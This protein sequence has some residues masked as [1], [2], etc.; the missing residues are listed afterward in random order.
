M[1]SNKT[2]QSNQFETDRSYRFGDYELDA[3]ER[4]LRRDGEIVSL[5]LKPLEVLLVLLERRGRV[6]S[7]EELIERVWP[8]SVVD[9]A[10]LARHV[11]TL[12]RAL[13]ERPKENG[14]EDHFIQTV[15]GRGYRFVASVRELDEK[16]AERVIHE[17]PAAG[18]A[19]PTV[20]SPAKREPLTGVINQRRRRAA[21]ALAALIAVV[22]A[23]I[24]FSK[25]ANGIESILPH[26]ERERLAKR[27]NVDPE[28]HQAYEKG[29]YHWKKRRSA[30]LMKAIEHFNEAIAR[31]PNYAQPY[32]GL[33]DCYVLMEGLTP[34]ILPP[35][36][37]YPKAK[38][39]A[40]KALQIDDQSAEA[41]TSMGRIKM[42]YDWDWMGAEK[43]FKLAIQ[44]DPDYPTAHQWYSVYLSVMGRHAEAIAAAEQAYALDQISPVTSRQLALNYYRARQYDKAIAH[45][46]KMLDLDP[47]AYIRLRDV[48]EHVYEQL[49]WY[50]Q[51]VAERVKVWTVSG[52]A[53]KAAALKAAYDRSGWKGYMQKTSDSIIERAMVGKVGSSTMAKI[54]A[55]LG[56]KDRTLEWLEKAYD[57]RS[58]GIIGIKS[59]PAFDW[60]HADPR[61]QYLLRRIG[62]A[63]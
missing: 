27:R 9:E 59:D 26:S 8:D 12:R 33:A 52:R 55:R 31:D 45:C 58:S 34:T 14:G 10:N 21:I 25:G 53:E 16:E 41:H 46:Q 28:A 13:G 5:P 39:A 11:Y 30:N 2:G 44:L 36:E 6:V 48:L 43:E 19:A 38:E 18:A 40:M 61:F 57:E 20:S 23:V 62:L 56:D 29:R 35:N 50:D 15:S 22:A 49:G 32:A 63:S 37:A 24:F 51:A 7:K 1:M 17:P 47:Q 4:V 42:D 60:L 3:A 54:Y